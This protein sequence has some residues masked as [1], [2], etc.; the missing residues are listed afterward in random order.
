MPDQTF[1]S[2]A[3]EV[4]AVGKGRAVAVL[5]WNNAFDRVAYKLFPQELMKFNKSLCES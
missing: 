2:S 5:C 1:A 3:E 4:E